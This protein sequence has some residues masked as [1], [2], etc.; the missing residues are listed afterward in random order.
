MLNQNLKHSWSKRLQPRC[1]F[2]FLFFLFL[3]SPETIPASGLLY[4]KL[5]LSEIL[6]LHIFARQA[7]CHHLGCDSVITLT[8]GCF[9]IASTSPSFISLIPPSLSGIILE[10]ACFT[11][12]KTFLRLGTSSVFPPLHPSAYNSAW[13][14]VGLNQ[15]TSVDFRISFLRCLPVRYFVIFLSFIQ[16]YVSHHLPLISGS[17]GRKS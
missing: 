16:L 12:V 14:M 17:M 2:L 6:V 5:P 4:M 8:A 3:N 7:L 10:V 9:T 15:Q 11:P 13:E 1:T